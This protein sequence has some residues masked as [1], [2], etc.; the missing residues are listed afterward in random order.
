MASNL[1]CF[2]DPLKALRQI[3]GQF[4]CRLGSREV[5]VLVVASLGLCLAPGRVLGQ[6]EWVV[7]QPFGPTLLWSV[8]FDAERDEFVAVGPERQVA[9]D[10]DISILEDHTS[11]SLEGAYSLALSGASIVIGQILQEGIG[12]SGDR[13]S[14]SQYFPGE[15]FWGVAYGDGQF[16]VV[17]TGGRIAT[18]SVAL[19]D[20]SAVTIDGINTNLYAICFGDGR[21]LTGNEDRVLSS[22]NGSD[23]K[24]HEVDLG[25]SVRSM[26]F[27]RERFVLVGAAGAVMVS[28]DGENWLPRDSGT[29]SSLR[30]VTFGDGLF[31]AVGGNGTIIYSID[32]GDSWNTVEVGTAQQINAVTFGRRM[33]HA[34]T[35]GG[36]V[37]ASRSIMTPPTIVVEVADQSVLAG[38]NV[39]L[40][41]SAAGTAPLA[42]SW[43]FE[44]VVIDGAD[45]SRLEILEIS[46]H[47]EG[48]YTV[49]VFNP[50]GAIT[51][52]PAFLDV[53]PV[54]TPPAIMEQPVSVATVEGEPLELSVVAEGTAPLVFRW[55]KGSQ[56]LVNASGPIL[57][58]ESAELSDAGRYSVSVSNGFGEAT[59]REVVV[60]VTPSDRVPEILAHPSGGTVFAGQAFELRV[61]DRAWPPPTYQW[62]RD[63]VELSG[64]HSSAIRFSPI[65]MEDSGAYHVRVTNLLGYADS[66]VAILKV[67]RPESAPVIVVQPEDGDVIVGD[68]FELAAAV[69]GH[70]KPTV[71]W[72]HDGEPIA[73]A[74]SES[75]SVDAARSEDE[76]RYWIEA[77]NRLGSVKSRVVEVV[78][79]DGRP[80][81]VD[82]PESGVVEFG[83]PFS[84]SIGA[85]GPGPM[86]YRWFRDDAELS[87]ADGPVFKIESVDFSH[88]GHYSVEV[89]NEWGA[90]RS[91]VFQVTVVPVNSAGVWMGEVLGG[92]GP[93]YFALYVRDDRSAVIFGADGHGDPILDRE[94]KIGDNG[95]FGFTGRYKPD[96]RTIVPEPEGSGVLQNDLVEGATTDGFLLQGARTYD[97]PA[98]SFVGFYRAG[99]AGT[100]A[101]ELLLIA[102]DSGRYVLSVE[103]GGWIGS[104]SGRMDA[105]GRD[106][107]AFDHGHLEF[108]LDS[109]AGILS[110]R[111][112]VSGGP[113]LTLGGLRDGTNR[114]DFLQ[115]TSLRGVTGDG[116]A[117][118]VTGFV[119]EGEGLSPVLIRGI[120]PGLLRYGVAGAL[121]SVNQKLFRSEEV[122]AVAGDWG[123]SPD[124]VRIQEWSNLA[125]AFPLEPES[126]DSALVLNLESGAYTVHLSSTAG[127]GVG[128]TEVY[129]VPEAA[130]VSTHSC[131]INLSTRMRVSGGEGVIIAG[132]V[133]SGEVPA[134]VLI[135]GVGPGL[136]PFGVREFLRNPVLSLNRGSD[137]FA[138]NDDWS[139][140][141]GAGI[142]SDLFD[143]IGAFHLKEGSRDAALLLWLEPG[144]YT[145]E[146]GSVDANTGLVLVEIY[147]VP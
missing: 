143:R 22:T 24:I 44:G 139:G 132:F 96:T 2:L 52:R 31:V 117:V 8:A 120:G 92:G 12:Y 109:E 112:T 89:G 102:D 53:L 82:L 125:G 113:T 21:F 104:A 114:V 39:R 33:F 30:G 101:G 140:T 67:V 50:A 25:V 95:S 45:S 83:R 35:S 42:Y 79:R 36:Q 127:A 86:S 10:V 100:V 135:R 4:L 110:G 103:I 63:E 141:D 47:D 81:L 40:E 59:S 118:M 126:G 57:T 98:L 11:E 15:S 128:L 97:H 16:V 87:G 72:Y 37:L 134:R 94:V 136:G 111:W 123:T 88:S 131:V 60:S 70:P 69:D 74:T 76:G 61:S 19:N 71:Q 137:R 64:E 130:V 107:L 54:D 138:T 55:F 26:A 121:R 49:S 28:D 133:I 91:D 119:V 146:V 106:H 99:I 145:A 66:E 5:R 124:A 48:T 20:W 68:I 41:V 85:D 23:W 9:W 13:D 116:A 6:K 17:G 38:S 27:G 80:H 77:R 51:G 115:N 93:G 147:A 1:L 142:P 34:V 84:V 32:R 65:R 90:T 105:A 122:L 29:T 75:F 73:L 7:Y 14:W 58:K 56:W 3:L 144:L 46:E 18:A 78:T 129:L 62:F 43:S 108:S